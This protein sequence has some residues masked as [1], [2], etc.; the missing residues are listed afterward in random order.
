MK[1]TIQDVIT[2]EKEKAAEDERQKLRAELKNM[3]Q[4]IKENAQMKVA[5][6]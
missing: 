5:L 6:N 3:D 1:S 2:R 4:L